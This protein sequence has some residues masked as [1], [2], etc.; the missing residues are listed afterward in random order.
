MA[1][2]S[3][4]FRNELVTK[5]INVLPQEQIKSVLQAF[6]LTSSSYDISHKPTELIPLDGFPE[7]VKSYI[8]SKAVCNASEGTLKQYRY[9]LF[10]FFRAV[11]KPFNAVTANDIRLYLYNIKQNRNASDRYLE[12][13]RITLNGFFQWLVANDYLLKNPCEKVE[14]I[15]FVEKQRKPLEPI[16]LET[17]RWNTHE[18]REKA[19]IDFLFSTGMRISEC[20]NVRLAD[21]DWSE[22]AVLIRKGKGG[23]QRVVYF[24]AESEVSLRKYLET[25]TDAT[26]ALFVSKRAPHQPL[27]SR[28]L[29]NIIREVSERSSMHVYPHLLR[30]TF[31]TSGLHG[32]MPVEKLQRLLGH[33]SPQTTLIYAKLDRVDLQ[34]EHQRIYA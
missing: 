3:E 28:A 7:V 20:A 26:D 17:F 30:H 24:N 1:S 15:R 16:E 10:D 14:K 27:K 31:A 34:R 13:I 12:C 5:L 4:R 33:A 22:R 32:G 19:L 21:I 9:N 11:P 6:D 23:K 8:A 18:V 2:T 29:E 25:R